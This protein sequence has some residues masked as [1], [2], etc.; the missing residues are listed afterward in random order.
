MSLTVVDGIGDGDNKH[1]RNHIDQ[2]KR[3]FAQR[4]VVGNHALAHEI[5][6]QTVLAA[7]K[8]VKS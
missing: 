2:P 3:P 8:D 7:I 4:V 6:A 1:H 5:F